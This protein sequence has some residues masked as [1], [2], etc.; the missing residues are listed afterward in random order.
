MNFEEVKQEIEKTLSPKRFLHSLGVAKRAEE[1]AKIYNQDIEKARLIGMV[2]DVA[3]EMSKEE[4]LQYAGD[5]GIIFDE[6]EKQESSLWHSKIG[7]DIAKKRFGFSDD[8]VQAIRYHTVG[9]IHMNTLDKIIYLA[10]KTE[11]NRNFIDLQKA[12]EISDKDLDEGIIYTTAVSVEY[13]M[14]KQSLIHP[15]TIH[16]MNQIIMNTRRRYEYG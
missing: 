6:I 5:N 8:M 9:N 10:D 11:E 1:L 7:A 13:S 4:S 15:D 2:H 12:K 14:K 3:K 16:V